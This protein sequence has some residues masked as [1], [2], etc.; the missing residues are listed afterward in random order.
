MDAS[1]RQQKV[2]NLGDCHRHRAWM[3][4]GGQP[5][6]SWQGQCKRSANCNARPRQGTGI[7]GARRQGGCRLVRA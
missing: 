7:Q 3:R 6:A 2:S 1:T 5:A 4:S